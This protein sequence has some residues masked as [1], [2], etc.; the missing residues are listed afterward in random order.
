MADG[1]VTRLD[2]SAVRALLAVLNDQLA[3]LEA[4]PGPVG[5]LALTTIAGLAEIYGQALARMLELADPDAVRR[6][7]DDEL[8]GHLVTLHGIHPEPVETRLATVIERLGAA[9]AAQGGTVELDRL[10]DGGAVLRISVGGRAPA[11]I[12]QVVRRAVLT[13]VPELADVTIESAGRSSAAAFVPLE[14]LMRT[15]TARLP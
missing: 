11:D 9:L 1:E 10:D 3:Q 7:L 5:E 14:A 13:S 15:A 2:D 12:E 8:I 4:M 6:M